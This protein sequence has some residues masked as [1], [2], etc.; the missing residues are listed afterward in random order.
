MRIPNWRWLVVFCLPLLM[1]AGGRYLSA[2]GGAMPEARFNPAVV[3]LR[4]GDWEGTELP[5]SP[6]DLARLDREAQLRRVYTNSSGDRMSAAVVYSS[7]WK[8]LHSAESCLTGAGWDIVK[9]QRVEVPLA[10][11][12]AP[13]TVIFTRNEQGVQLVEFYMFVNRQG[14]TAHWIDQFWMLIR[15]RGRGETACHLVL[16]QR[17]GPEQTAEATAETLRGFAQLILPYVQQSLQV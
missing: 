4:L 13:G 11:Q 5:V 9:Q 7:N 6:E 2:A 12:Q 15:N 8:G 3:P 17:V 10:G 1:A 14:V 16:S